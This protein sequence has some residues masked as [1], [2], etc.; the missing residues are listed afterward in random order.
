MAGSDRNRDRR[1]QDTG[2]ARRA[3]RQDVP[4]RPPG[5]IAGDLPSMSMNNTASE[6]RD[7]VRGKLIVVAIL[8]IV[9]LPVWIAIFFG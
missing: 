9:S 3:P 5:W 6:G 2:P 1:Q 7:E 8:I 4:E